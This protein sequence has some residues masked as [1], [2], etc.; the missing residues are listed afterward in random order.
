MP[1]LSADG[2]SFV[3][4]TDSAKLVSGDTNGKWDTFVHDRW[5][6][7]PT[8]TASATLTVTPTPPPHTATPTATATATASATTAWQRIHLPL[9][10]RP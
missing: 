5:P 4:E 9:I 8:P 1:C 6:P 2:R 10:M 3:F 7:L